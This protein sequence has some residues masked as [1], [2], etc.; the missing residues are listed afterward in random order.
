MHLGCLRPLPL[1]DDA[2]VPEEKG[3]ETS[4]RVGVDSSP[5]THCLELS[6]VFNRALYFLAILMFTYIFTY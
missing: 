2:Y 3:S 6:N 5:L 1:T 4:A